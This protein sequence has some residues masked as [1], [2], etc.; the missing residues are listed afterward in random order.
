M[1]KNA[2]P[3]RQTSPHLLPSDEDLLASASVAKRRPA[4]RSAPRFASSFAEIEP[5]RSEGLESS[6]GWLSAPAL[7][8][9]QVPQLEEFGTEVLNASFRDIVMLGDAEDVLVASVL[10]STFPPVAAWPKFRVLASTMPERIRAL[11]RNL[12]LKRTLFLVV[13]QSRLTVETA[14]LFDFFLDRVKGRAATPPGMSFVAI[15]NAGS[16]LEEIARRERFRR[17]FINSINARGFCS[18]FTYSG[19]VPAALLGMDVGALLE[20]TV[21]SMHEGAN[22][23]PSYRNSGVKLGAA[24]GVLKRAGR[25]KLHFLLSPQIA[26]L[27]GWL[28]KLISN[29]G[30]G[31][32]PVVDEPTI[33]AERYSDDR[34]FV[35]IRYKDS[36]SAA[37]ERRIESVKQRDFPTIEIAL[38]DKLDLGAEFLRWEIAA[39]TLA[40]MLGLSG[41]RVSEP[42]DRRSAF[43]PTRDSTGAGAHATGPF[44]EEG[45]LSLFVAESVR[46]ALKDAGSLA[47]RIRAF[48]DLSSTGGYLAISA[49]I[50]PSPAVDREIAALRRAI[51]ERRGVATVFSYESAIDRDF[52]SAAN[53]ASRAL[54]LQITQDYRDAVSIPGRNYDFAALDVACQRAEFDALDKKGCRVMRIHL[55]GGDPI[56]ALTKLRQLLVPTPAR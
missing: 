32:I 42:D 53:D 49:F 8:M 55:G 11:E 37:F 14:A 56:G 35:C 7:M 52:G 17:V 19:L 28:S 18:P 47:D 5:P 44:A 36:T 45:D 22:E 16:P 54:F 38:A 23:A 43:V 40:L 41:E 26:A 50:A 21:A 34:A 1:D 51:A 31:I 24:L 20:R 2:I 4:V 33:A 48:F 12:D 10:A 25:D 6:L 46:V 9:A 15:T 29:A 3:V 30:A 27:G 13:G 39:A